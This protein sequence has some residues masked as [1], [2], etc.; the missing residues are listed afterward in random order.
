M[1]KKIFYRFKHAF[2]PHF[3]ETE[4][5]TLFFLIILL[6]IEQRLALVQL[7]IDEYASILQ[8]ADLVERLEGL[9]CYSVIIISIIF[10]FIALAIN[11]LKN[12]KLSIAEKRG[13]ASIFYVFLSAISFVSILDY[14]GNFFP[15]LW[16]RFEELYLFYL[17]IRSLTTMVL[18][19]MIVRQGASKVLANQMTDEQISR[20]E[21]LILLILSIFFFF[22]LRQTHTIPVTLSLSYFYVTTLLFFYRQL[23][24]KIIILQ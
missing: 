1:I 17:L 20:K 24:K 3:S 10:F 9:L 14:M 23:S 8:T 2:Y 21:L 15:S 13:F 11:A 22:N 4:L 18:T 6:I 16:S 5:T 19:F 12:R 7:V